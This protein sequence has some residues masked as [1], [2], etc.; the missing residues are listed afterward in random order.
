M[1]R[2][3]FNPIVLLC[4]FFV[5]M[6]V[7]ADLNG[8][9]TGVIKTPDGN[10]LQVTYNFKVDGTKLTGTAESPAGTITVDDGTVTGDTFKFKVTVDGNDYPHSGKLYADSCGLD[11]DFGGNKVHTTLKRADK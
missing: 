4:C 2:K 5:V 7:I 3:F 9:W 8:K 10:D 1:K 11:I 6:A